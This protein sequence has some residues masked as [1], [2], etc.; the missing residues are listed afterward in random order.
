MRGQEI[1]IP[2]MMKAKKSKMIRREV[3]LQKTEDSRMKR[4]LCT[5]RKL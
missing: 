5:P 1:K 4:K 2:L 3:F